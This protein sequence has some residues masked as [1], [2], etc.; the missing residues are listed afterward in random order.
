MDSE[1]QEQIYGNYHG[2]QEAGFSAQSIGCK[3][4]HRQEQCQGECERA[5]PKN[6]ASTENQDKIP[7]DV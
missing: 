3:M 7:P 6:D 4:K 5:E 1:K 2:S